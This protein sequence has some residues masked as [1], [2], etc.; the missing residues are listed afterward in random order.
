MLSLYLR[1]LRSHTLLT[2]MATGATTSSLG[3]AL[4]QHWIEDRPFSEH[5]WMRTLRFGV[6][7]GLI[8]A[9]TA[10]RW[11]ALL[12][13]IQYPSMAKTL[14][15]RLIPD[16]LIFSPLATTM[17]FYGMGTLEGRKWGDI[18][19]R[20]SENMIP[21]IQKQ[22]I[23]FG[24]AVCIN[25]TVVPLYA[26]PP[27]MNLIGLLWMTY[28]ASV[29]SAETKQDSELGLVEAALEKVRDDEPITQVR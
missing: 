26:R 19:R 17:F 9:P 13:R 8:F 28:L 10:N 25:F 15:V 1:L 7:S 22:W 3:D 6:Y 23:V 12:N 20:L 29:N 2:Q 16:A 11:H 27:F 14:V 4:S 24:P 5:D 18:Q 21:L